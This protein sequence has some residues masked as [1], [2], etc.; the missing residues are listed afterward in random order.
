MKSEKKDIMK[1]I[2]NYVPVN[3]DCMQAIFITVKI[4]LTLLAY[5]IPPYFLQ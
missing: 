3:Y 4:K 1:K 2:S 5:I